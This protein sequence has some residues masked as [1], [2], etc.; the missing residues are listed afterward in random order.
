VKLT[1]KLFLTGVLAAALAGSLVPSLAAQQEGANPEMPGRPVYEKVCS[2]CHG[3]EGQGDKAP[4]LIP[5][6]WNYSQALD[7]VRHG[8][9]C[10]MPSFTESELS[11]E[12]AKQIVDY[13]KT[14]S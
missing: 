1:L 12:Q 7:I 4:T 11:D 14:L 2:R 3:P 10:G 9:S 5:F 6:R 8:G 13:L